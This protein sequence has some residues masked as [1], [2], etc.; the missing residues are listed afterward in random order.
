MQIFCTDV[1]VNRGQAAVERR[2]VDGDLK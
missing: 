2:S 1:N